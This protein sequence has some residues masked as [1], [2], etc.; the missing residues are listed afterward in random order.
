[1]A[2][3]ENDPFL[4]NTLLG[5]ATGAAAGLVVRESADDGYQPSS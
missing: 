4:A 1:M 5:I 3:P 2:S